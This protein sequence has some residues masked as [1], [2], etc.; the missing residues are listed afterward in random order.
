M[1]MSPPSSRARCTPKS[2]SLAEDCHLRNDGVNAD[3]RLLTIEK[4]RIAL[5][6][7]N[8]CIPF[9][10]SARSLLLK[11]CG[12]QAD[13]PFHITLHTMR[14]TFGS[15]LAIE[16]VSLR[17]IQKLM[18]HK[19]ITTTE[20]YAHLSGENLSTAVQRLEAILPKSLPSIAGG[21][22]NEPPQAVVT[23]R[24]NWCGGPESNRH[25]PCGPRDFKS[26]ASTSSATPAPCK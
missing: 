11:R 20:R 25:G 22:G 19:S 15:W 3:D 21:D 9:S 1:L 13:P 7:K 8:I 16:G 17:A 6:E 14:H 12:L 26:L 23:T 10:A 18:G 24:N 2:R 4:Y 5:S